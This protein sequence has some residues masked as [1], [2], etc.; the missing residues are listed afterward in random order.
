MPARRPRSCPPPANIAAIGSGGIEDE[1]A[2][3]R[4]AAELVG[5]QGEG[6]DAKRADIEGDPARRLYRIGVDDG[7]EAAGDAAHLGDRLDDARFVVG[8]H[9]GDEGRLGRCGKAALKVF[10]VD[11]MP[12]RSTGIRSAPTAAA[13]SDACS[14]AQTRRRRRPNP[15]IASVLASV[16]PEVKTTAAGSAPTSAATVIPR[17]LDQ[18]AGG[19]T[20]PVNRRRI[21]DQWSAASS[22]AAI[23]AGVIGTV[24]LWSR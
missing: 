1:G 11:D 19:A 9:H 20:E 13:S 22:M 24:A 6:G 23:A 17:I 18:P 21:A 8:E 7:A 10:E 15:A 2:R 12:V 5:R 3:A 4:R 14:V 16:A